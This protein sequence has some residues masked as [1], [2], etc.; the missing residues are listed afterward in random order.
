MDD[1]DYKVRLLQDYLD[2]EHLT[3][4]ELATLKMFITEVDFNLNNQDV[5]HSDE[6]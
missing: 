3:D 5:D 4:Q 2:G 1:K 6:Y